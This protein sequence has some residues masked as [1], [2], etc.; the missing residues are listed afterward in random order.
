MKRKLNP[1]VLTL[2]ASYG[3]YATSG[4]ATC[5]ASS[6]SSKL[7]IWINHARNPRAR[8]FDFPSAGFTMELPKPLALANVAVRLLQKEADPGL[9]SRNEFTNLVRRL[10]FGRCS[11]RHGSFSSSV[12]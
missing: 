2:Q 4:E 1:G 11:M 12:C 3:E 6:E 5:T 10:T 7:A 9:K 8:T